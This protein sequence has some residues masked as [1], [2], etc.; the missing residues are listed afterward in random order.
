MYRK[1]TQDISHLS[2]EFISAAVVIIN[3]G[4]DCLG[5]SP[6]IFLFRLPEI[7]ICV[8]VCVN[9]SYLETFSRTFILFIVLLAV[10][11]TCINRKVYSFM[12]KCY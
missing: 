4:S 10:L 2:D 6:R 8:C 9:I 11:Y 1:I 3:N 7:Y 12:E 5:S